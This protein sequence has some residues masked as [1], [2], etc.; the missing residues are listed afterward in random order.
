MIFGVC[1]NV[2]YRPAIHNIGVNIYRIYGVGNQDNVIF[3]KQVSDVSG[4]TFCAVRD[5]YFIGVY[6]S[7]ISPVVVNNCFTQEFVAL[8]RTIAFKGFG[9]CKGIYTFMKL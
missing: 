5:E 1:V 4:V 2:G 6:C 7:A 8:F 9:A 3:G